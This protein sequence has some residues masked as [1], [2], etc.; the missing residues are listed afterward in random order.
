MNAVKVHL[1]TIIIYI[2]FKYS[3]RHTK[4]QKE[5]L[6]TKYLLEIGLN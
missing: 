5:A 2:F 3:Y 6:F 1:R 4:N